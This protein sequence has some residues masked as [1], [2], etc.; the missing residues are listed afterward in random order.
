MKEMLRSFSGQSKIHKTNINLKP[1]SS[2]FLLLLTNN[3]NNNNEPPLFIILQYINNQVALR[4]N[5]AS[6]FRCLEI[7]TKEHSRGSI[8]RKHLKLF[9]RKT[10]LQ[11]FIL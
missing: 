3:N 8:L 5:F 9:A 10:L 1:V 2:D 11:L 4:I 7:L 6:M